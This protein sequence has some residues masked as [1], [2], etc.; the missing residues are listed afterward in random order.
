MCAANGIPFGTTIVQE[1]GKGYSAIPAKSQIPTIEQQ[2]Q[3]FGGLEPLKIAGLIT[4]SWEYLTQAPNYPNNSWKCNPGKNSFVHIRLQEEK[5]EIG[6]CSEVRTGFRTGEIKLKSEQWRNRKLDLVEDCNG[7]LY[8]CTFEA[9]NPD[10]LNN[11]PSLA[12]MTLIKSGHSELV[13]KWGKIAVALSPKI[14]PV[15]IGKAYME[16]II[17]RVLGRTAWREAMQRRGLGMWTYPNDERS[18]RSRAFSRVLDHAAPIYSAIELLSPLSSRSLTVDGSYVEPSLASLPALAVDMSILWLL[19]S[20][21]TDLPGYI[22]LKL[23]ANAATHM[24]W[25]LGSA[26]VQKMRSFSH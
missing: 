24:A 8:R 18:Y 13:Q 21:Q 7:C 19:M 4:N 14:S 17:D 10:F 2:R 12:V 20:V 3:V 26:A 25:D 16:S 22:G 9:E 5:G 6:V 11:L 1:I 15:A 23:L